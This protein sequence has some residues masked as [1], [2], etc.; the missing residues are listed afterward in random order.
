MKVAVRDKRGDP[1]LDRA[2]GAEQPVHHI[3]RVGAVR[4]PHAL[5]EQRVAE[6]KGP[7]R[8]HPVERER[9]QVAVP[10]R[11]HR[12]VAE[13]V[14]GQRIPAAVVDAPVDEAA[15]EHRPGH[16]RGGGP[17]E[18]PP[19]PARGYPR[20]RPPRGP[21]PPARDEPP[22]PGRGGGSPPRLP[23]PAYPG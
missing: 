15:H 1:Q 18:Q 17:P 8:E 13:L 14:R 21:P 9:L 23:P 22:P 10:A 16:R 3:R 4:H 20:P 11:V 19:I 5:L 12:A 2:G 7:D 6:R